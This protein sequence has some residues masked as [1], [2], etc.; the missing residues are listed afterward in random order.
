MISCIQVLLS[1]STCGSTSRKLVFRLNRV[2]RT[3]PG[4]LRANAP[5]AVTG[6]AGAAPAA[7]ALAARAAAAAAD[8]RAQCVLVA[9]P[10][11]GALTVSAVYLLDPAVPDAWVPAVRSAVLVK[12]REVGRCRFTAS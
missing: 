7:A 12:L 3:R 1:N 5:P 9:A 6:A 8:A 11:S 4:V 2:L 10:G